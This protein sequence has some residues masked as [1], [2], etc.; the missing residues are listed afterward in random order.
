MLDGESISRSYD[1]MKINIKKFSETSQKDDFGLISDDESTSLIFPLSESTKSTQLTS[2]IFDGE[3][4]S[5]IAL[6]N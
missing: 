5:K 3:I 1:S 2:M 6:K 4:F